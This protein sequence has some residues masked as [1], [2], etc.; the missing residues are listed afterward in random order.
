[1]SKTE[2]EKLLNG[3]LNLADKMLADYGE[4][5]PYATAL[6]INNEIEDLGIWRGN[7]YP[8]SKDVVKD[9]EE[10][11]RKGVREGSYKATALVLNVSMRKDK[12]NGQQDSILLRME[13]KSGLALDIFKPYQLLQLGK[14][15]YG[16][17]V[18]SKGKKFFF[19]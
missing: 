4:F 16:D 9:L 8:K 13:H 6:T 18:A 2:L 14:V 7:D 15:Q 5:Y 17:I 12:D 19:K 3:S 11:L 1:M 10:Y